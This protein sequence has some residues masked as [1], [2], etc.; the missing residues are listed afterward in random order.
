MRNTYVD[1]V[2]DIVP[3]GEE[4]WHIRSSECECR[5]AVE[6]TAEAMTMLIHNAFDGREE[7]EEASERLGS[8]RQ[9]LAA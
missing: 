1:N 5:P 2:I 4:A 9:K 7:F 8:T 6:T 3:K